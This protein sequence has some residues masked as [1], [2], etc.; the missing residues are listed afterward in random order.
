MTRSLRVEVATVL[1]QGIAH[2]A[3]CKKEKCR[4]C[5]FVVE[6]LDQI[7]NLIFWSAKLTDHHIANKKTRQPKG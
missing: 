1:V 2:W 3:G 5:E 6:S 7:A 4:E